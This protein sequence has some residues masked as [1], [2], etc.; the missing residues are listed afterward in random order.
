MV[1]YDVF[2][3]RPQLGKSDWLRLVWRAI[4]MKVR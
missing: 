1:D 3:Q 4:R 2:H